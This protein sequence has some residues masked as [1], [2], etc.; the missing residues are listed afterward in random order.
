MFKTQHLPVRW[1]GVVL[2]VYGNCR[3]VSFDWSSICLSVDWG[4]SVCCWSCGVCYWSWGMVS[5]WSMGNIGSWGVIS[6][7]GSVV[8]DWCW[9]VGFENWGG[10]VQWRG[11]VREGETRRQEDNLEDFFYY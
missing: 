3:S 2:C 1:V 5:Y 8:S 6:Y 10:G 4:W 9:G 7:W 11:S